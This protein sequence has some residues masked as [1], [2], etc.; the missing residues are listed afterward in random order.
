MLAIP[1]LGEGKIFGVLVVR[2]QTSGDYSEET[3]EV[4]QSL[5][6][7][8]AL[9]ILNARVFRE[10]ERKSSELEV[11]SQHKSE[12]LASMSHELRTPL[13]AVIGFSQVLLE[14]MFGDLNDR[15]D[16]YLR[17]ILGAGQHLLELLNDVLDLSKVEAGRM[18]L[19]W[20]TFAVREAIDY[21]LSMVR[22]RAQ[23]RSI[24]I[25]C[26]ITPGVD[27]LFA[28]RLRITQ[29][30][31]N[32]VTNAVKFTPVGGRIRVTAS[33]DGTEIAISVSD[34]GP[35]VPVEDRE[36]I[37][38]SF[39]QGNR[40]A[41]RN[42]GTGLGLTLSRR[43]VEL[44]AGRMWLET[45]L[46]A[47]STFGFAIPILNAPGPTPTTDPHGE[48]NGSVVVVIEDDPGSMELLTLYLHGA[49]ITVVGAGSGAAGLNFT[50]QVRPSAVILDLTL[51]DIDGWQLLS[52]LKGDP[53]TAN[54][55]VLIVSV[56]DERARG[57]AMGAADYL[58]K[59]VGRDLVLRSLT[60][61]GAI[62]PPTTPTPAAPAAPAAPNGAKQ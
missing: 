55:P 27:E 14:R 37:F 8:S 3:A 13:N 29:V 39:Q 6:D 35:G 38:E 62:P 57:L 41:D 44:H 42:E 26:V 40:I 2:R 58:V 46:G 51:P 36:R 1:L 45:Q 12:F 61:I 59:P 56:V 34:S 53:T 4:L 54:I 21:S 15:Q 18:E 5:A 48:S 23:Q 17:D 19:N 7:Q 47:G 52:T 33:T 31:V 43:I 24:R 25:D 9:A 32:L 30:I 10:L 49:D 20:S 28:D 60:R 50:R 16:E 22:E 11:A